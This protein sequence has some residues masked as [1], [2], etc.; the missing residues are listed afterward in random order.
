MTYPSDEVGPAPGAV[1]GPGRVVEIDAWRAR[2]ARER[3]LADLSERFHPR[4]RGFLAGLGVGDPDDGANEV[5]RRVAAR[6]ET[7][8]G[9]E[10]GLA[11]L[12]FAVARNLARDEARRTRRRVRAEPVVAVPER[13][14]LAA[15]V[16]VI[17][18]RSV[19]E[20]L[21]VLTPEQREVLLCRVVADLSIE[22]TAI[23][24]GRPVTAVKALQR[25][26][27]ETLRRHL[28]RS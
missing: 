3:R 8:T 14:G 18:D 19:V 16:D 25:R 26:A 9:G 10:D 22:T 4:V 21:R 11:A 6:L 23:I 13:P 20:I 7:V 28:D 12:V 1:A 24:V 15:D 17:A 27:V 5:I 2:R